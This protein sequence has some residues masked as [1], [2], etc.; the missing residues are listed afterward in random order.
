MTGAAD[1]TQAVLFRR[2]RD[3]ELDLGLAVIH[4]RF[5]WLRER[6]IRQW[7]RRMPLEKYRE[8]QQRGENFALLVGAEIAVVLSLMRMPSTAWKEELGDGPHL[9]LGTLAT[10]LR[11]AGRG[12]GARAVREALVHAAAAGETEVYLDCVHGNGFMPRY[13]QAMGFEWV[14]RKDAQ[15]PTG[16]FDAVLMRKALTTTAGA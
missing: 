13:Y 6:G 1:K 15:Y 8:R 14:T 9:W 7:L 5:D 16:I 10:A 4:E 11:F 2:L 3:E 12:L